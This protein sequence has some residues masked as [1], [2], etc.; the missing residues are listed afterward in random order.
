I[1]KRKLLICAYYF[2]PIGTPRSYRW[3]E[4]VTHLSQKGWEIDILTINTYSK[5][6]NYDPKLMD[7]L[8]NELSIFRT[9]PGIMHHFSNLLLSKTGDNS[10]YS[11]LKAHTSF[12]QTL[13]KSLFKIFEK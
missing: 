10:A 8:P 2:P 1:M 9:Y 6:P 4:F 12:R 5:H 3:R 13:W 7:N 11:S